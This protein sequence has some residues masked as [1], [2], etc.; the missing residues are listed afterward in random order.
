[1]PSTR[2]VTPSVRSAARPLRGFLGAWILAAAAACPA[3]E[4][5]T[6]TPSTNDKDPNTAPTNYFEQGILARSGEVVQGLGPDLLGDRVN[7]YGGGLEF[8]HTDVS[9]PGN[10]ALPVAVGRHLSAGTRQARLNSGLFGD[11]DLEI[12]RLHTVAANADT[13]FGNGLNAPNLARCSQFQAPPV[14]TFIANSGSLAAAPS[15]K[16]WDGYHLYLPGQGD[17]TLLGR[18]AS[19]GDPAVAPNDLEPTDGLAYPVVTKQHWQFSCL[20]SLKRGSGEGFLAHAPDG[21]QIRFDHMVSRAYP[22]Y[23]GGGMLPRN[24]I[25][26]LPTQ[27]SDRFGNWVRYTYAGTDGW[28]LASIV[29]SDGR[30]IT[31]AYVGTSNRIQS[32]NDGTR[33]WTYVYDSAGALQSVTLPD[34][35][36]WTFALGPLAR[37]PFSKGD[38]DCVADGGVAGGT[39]VTGSITHPSGAVGTF[40][41]KL[42]EHGRSNVPG[43]QDN[44]GVARVSRYFASY[45]LLSKTL[46]GPGLAPMTWSYAYS[47]PIGSFGP[48]VGCV[49]TKTV[50]V[51]DPHGH[52][53]RNTYGTQFGIDE[54]LLIESAQGV[55][56]AGALRTTRHTYSLPNRGPFPALV[57]YHGG[58]AD[59]MSRIHTPQES[60]VVTQQGVTFTQQ[61]TGFDRFAR[62][63][64]QVRSSSL[65]H[66][67]TESTTYY[68]QT[69]LW[70]LGQVASR[71]VDGMV[72]SNTSFDPNTA[73]PLSRFSFGQRVEA[74]RFNADGTLDSVFDGLGNATSFSNYRRGLAQRIAY[75]DGTAVTGVV[76][77]LGQLSSVTNE[78]G[79][80]WNYG[81]DAMGRLASATPPAG[82]ATPY[83][84][85]LLTFTQVPTAEYGLEANHWRQTITEGNAVTV[86][87]FDARWRKRLTTTYDAANPTATRRMQLFQ[88][89]AYNRTVFASYPAR[90]IASVTAQPPGTRTSHDALGRVT[91]TLADS[92]LGLLPT[93]FNYL[94]GFRTQSINPRGFGTITAFQAFDDPDETSITAIASPEGVRVAITRDVFGKP[95]AIERTGIDGT[96]ATRRYVYDAQQRLCKTIEPET[97]ATVQATDAVGNVVWRASGLAL[98]A[99]A[100][101]LASVP[102]SRKI[103]H[104][105]DARNRP[106]TTTHGDGSASITR[107]YTPDGLLR[108][109]SSAGL[110]WTYGYNNRRLRV[111][112]VLSS[113]DGVDAIGWGIDANGHVATL[114]YPD[115]STL[116]YAPN[117]LGEPTRAGSYVTGVSHHP[118]GELATYTLANGVVHTVSQNLRG[119]PELWRD[120]GGS[121]TVVQ[122]RHAYDA[123]GNVAAISDELFATASRAMAYDGLDRLVRADGIWGAGSFRYD[124]LDNLRASV[125]GTRTLTHDIDPV[126]NRLT[127]LSGSQTLS[128]AYDVNGNVTQRG[129]QVF[130]FDIA[131]RMTG[132]AGRA[133]YTYDGHG[134]RT[135]V[136]Y[137]NGQSARHVYDQSGRLLQSVHSAQGA[138][139]YIHLAGTLVAEVNSLTGVSYVHSDLLGSPVART[140]GSGLLLSRTRYE[141]Y[142]A[143]AAGTNPKGVGFTG[144]LNDADT[145]LVY[146]QQRYYDPIGARFLS[147]DA[148]ATDAKD[149]DRFSRYRYA[150]NDPYSFIDPDGRSDW[151]AIYK[152]P[153]TGGGGGANVGGGSVIGSPGSAAAR[154]EVQGRVDAKAIP[155]PHGVAVQSEQAQ[156]LAARSEV[157]GGA[158]LY[159]MGTTGKSQAAEAQ[160]WSLEHPLA[161]G[162]AGRYGLPA[163]NVSHANFIEASTLRQGTPFITR[164]APGIGSNIGGGIE[165]VV[166]SGGVQMKWFTGMP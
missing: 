140:N 125:V 24:E 67:R 26:I 90:T 13:W 127:G 102:S 94:S 47:V 36:Q 11:W 58:V 84:P 119:F 138:T 136:A 80:T 66:S 131:N 31:F 157:Q 29:S 72:E 162:Y 116:G 98:P 50:T 54:G 40:V 5:V 81:Y 48:C 22:S 113:P 62:P 55:T 118:N 28:R 33:T 163:E 56:T 143:T 135:R 120:A 85:R 106:T 6:V 145:G 111:S 19:P 77:N 112:E 16:Y 20:P 2:L 108:Q 41:L 79:T 57:G 9:L 43:R 101:D 123:N 75:A 161:Q 69:R 95:L 71:G 15:Y 59:S 82:D 156:A 46:A 35:S 42:T 91:Q 25:W 114:T 23:N 164:P 4:A 63:I 121:G 32:V 51:T 165:V 147:V 103:N 38:P 87:H 107:S 137:A 151:N 129:S 159:R 154:R 133:T 152:T 150:A 78:A 7:E 146:M 155:T 44:C 83:K 105:Y 132:A 100:C 122:D 10:H 109:V 1:M 166:P 141:P 92:E 160:F 97:G 61:A 64:G 30:S 99:A 115:G 21:T 144:H 96:R 117:A 73:L 148:E 74:Y 104:A 124:A 89:D 18:Y 8:T 139:T 17:Q 149:A 65:G 76:N 70:V 68:D 93:T 12:P 39:P 128:M 34:A 153:R 134:R 60:R 37:D 27:V 126:T 86:N 52:V 3:Q 49:S 158:T 110:T 130:S 88:H 142:G 45:S 14:A 53:T